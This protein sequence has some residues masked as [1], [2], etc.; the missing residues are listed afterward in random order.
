MNRNNSMK[1]YGQ[2]FRCASVKISSMRRINDIGNQVRPVAS[3]DLQDI[4]AGTHN[5]SIQSSMA[6]E[7]PQDTRSGAQPLSRRAQVKPQLIKG[8]SRQISKVYVL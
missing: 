8:V 1:L 6:D 7:I 3:H 2:K 5:L 4:L